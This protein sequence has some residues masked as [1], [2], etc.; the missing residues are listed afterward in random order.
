MKFQKIPEFIA[1]EEIPRFV[2]KKNLLLIF[3]LLKAA[4]IIALFVLFLS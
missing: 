2:D 3:V 1:D 4:T